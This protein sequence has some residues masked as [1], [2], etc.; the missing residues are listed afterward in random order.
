M[1]GRRYE[2]DMSQGSILKNV[3]LFAIP[4]ILGNFLQLMYNAADIIVVGR[5]AGST[6]M[7]SVGAT[8]S[9]NNLI[10]SVFVGLS[11][12]VSVVVSKSY[13]SKDYEGIHRSVH[14]AVL[15]SFFVG[16]AALIIG[17]CFSG[18]VLRLMG[19]PE[20]E[21]F[22]GAVLYMRLYFLGVPASLA[23]NFGSAVLRAFGDTK[24]PLYILACTGIVNVVLNLVFVIVFHLG[25]AGVAISTAIANYLSAAAVIFILIKS[26]GPYKLHIKK[27]KIYSGELKDIAKVGL[28]AGLQSSVFSLANSVIQSAVNSFG[29]AAMAGCAAGANIEGFV[30]TAMNAF[31]Q[32]TITSVSQNIGA[33]NEKR[34]KKSI[35]VPILSVGAVG[36]ILG[37]LSVVFARPLLGIYITDSPEAIEYGVVRMIVSG[38]P[39]FLCGIMEVIGGAL[40]GL[41]HSTAGAVNSLIGACGTRLLWI[42]FVLPHHRS[43][44]MLFMCWPIS[45]I[46]VMIMH[47]IVLAVNFKS[48]MKKMLAEN[49]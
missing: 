23:Y 12:G 33:K 36:F 45:W 19:T 34:V 30:Y 35:Y 6:A 21:V 14:T 40:R 8:G 31:Y 28:P 47:T 17:M 10:I 48:D 2:L 29:T 42:T 7:A 46:I 41:G 24:R 11:V 20:G 37:L 18:T 3:F 15:L 32:A 9:V 38:L 49:N 26:D 4:L 16:I 39:Y 44:G 22:D 43:I 1:K 27:L 13:G 5:W 25:V